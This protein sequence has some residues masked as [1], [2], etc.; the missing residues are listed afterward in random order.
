MEERNQ[1]NTLNYIAIA[2]IVACVVSVAALIVAVVGVAKQSSIVVNPA[3]GSTSDGGSGS[4]VIVQS[5]PSSGDTLNG[6]GRIWRFHIGHFGGNTQYI[7]EASGQVRGYDVD[8]V[9]KVCQIANK[10]C[11]IAWD[12]YSNCWDSQAGQSARGGV[13]LMGNWYD[14]CIGWL[15][16]RTRKRTF[17]FSN[18]FGRAYPVGLYVKSG[19]TIAG[20]PNL[21]GVKIGILDGWYADEHCLARYSHIREFVETDANVI[22]HYPTEQDLVAALQNNEVAAGFTARVPYLEQLDTVDLF[23]VQ[24]FS[25]NLCVDGGVSL[26]MP[27]ANSELAAWFNPAFARLIGTRDYD[28]ICQDLTEAHGD[29]PGYDP[30]DYCIR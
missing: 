11:I 12:L 13:G 27:K 9:N 16:T 25:E 10:N 20:Y 23:N 30:D 2:V 4:S 28:E 17:S 15:Q 19:G 29:M 7:D 3:G 24:D 18:E 21:S 6:E 5:A 22:I 14:A 1:G 26:M 8:V